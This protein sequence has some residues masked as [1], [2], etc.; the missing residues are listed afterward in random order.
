MAEEKGFESPRG[1]LRPC[2]FSR[3]IHSAGLGY[4]SKEHNNNYIIAFIKSQYNYYCIYTRTLLLKYLSTDWATTRP[5]LMAQ[6]T[7]LCPRRASPA[8]NILG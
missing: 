5:S 2:R 7:K 4:S 8:A 6:T 1:P 3:P